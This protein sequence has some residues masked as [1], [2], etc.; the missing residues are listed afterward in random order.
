MKTKNYTVYLL[1]VIFSFFSLVHLSCR[2]KDTINNSSGM[3]YYENGEGEIDSRGGT[4]IVGDEASDIKGTYIFVPEDAVSAPV[5]IKITSATA[6]LQI[7][8]DTSIPIVKFEPDSLIFNIPVEL[9]IIYKNTLNTHFIRPYSY[10]PFEYTMI[11]TPLIEVDNITNIVKTQTEKLSYNFVSADNRIKNGIE[12]LNISGTIGVRI[13]LWGTYS[14]DG[15]IAIP[16]NQNIIDWDNAM[17][18]LLDGMLQSY[19]IFDV[20]LY[21]KANSFFDAPLS[22]LRLCIKRIK[23]GEEYYAVVLK[24]NETTPLYTTQNLVFYGDGPLNTWFSGT[25]LIFY[26]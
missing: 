18:V 9:G 10:F 17:E 24:D 7:P 15:L 6:D 19:S 12:M 23:T 16:T 26:F 3:P 25:P 4:V 8:G 20:K 21:N 14:G 5:I 13:D 11:E 22:T 2:K 1:I